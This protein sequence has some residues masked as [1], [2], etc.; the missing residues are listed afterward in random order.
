MPVT[1]NEFEVLDT[2]QGEAARADGGA[3]AQPG[4]QP[5]A[6]DLRRWL[7]EQAEQELRLQA[8]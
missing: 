1:I 2:P 7:D 3:P 5:E 4:R 8:H 6:Q